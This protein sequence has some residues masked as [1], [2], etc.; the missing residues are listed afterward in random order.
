M[1]SVHRELIVLTESGEK[2]TNLHE[3]INLLGVRKQ[4]WLTQIRRALDM[5]HRDQHGHVSRE[6]MWGGIGNSPF[7][8][9]A[10]RPCRTFSLTH[11]TSPLSKWTSPPKI[12][13]PER[14]HTE[15]NVS[16][17]R[18]PSEVMV[19]K[20]LVV[21]NATP[22]MPSGHPVAPETNAHTS[23]CLLLS[24]LFPGDREMTSEIEGVA[25]ESIRLNLKSL[26]NI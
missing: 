15:N 2:N 16:L 22:S 18:E 20:N 12:H 1:L 4:I 21:L 23:L 24:D 3:I 25:L 5:A 7:C 19:S 10:M 9:L 14:E 26:I 8:L 17:F 11:K 6:G 13:F